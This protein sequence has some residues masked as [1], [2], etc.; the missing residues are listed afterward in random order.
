MT[1]CKYNL[2]VNRSLPGTI[3]VFCYVPIILLLLLYFC[4]VF[5]LNGETV[6]LLNYEIESNYDYICNTRFVIPGN[7]IKK[8]LSH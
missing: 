4:L 2:T 3:F 6:I 5:K 8:N 7:N 1:F